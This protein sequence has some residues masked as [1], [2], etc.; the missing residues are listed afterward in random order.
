MLEFKLLCLKATKDLLLDLFNSEGALHQIITRDDKLHAKKAGFL[1]MNK[2]SE[3]LNMYV[4]INQ[5]FKCTKEIYEILFLMIGSQNYSQ[6]NA[7]SDGTI[8][9]LMLD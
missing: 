2:I 3:H 9:S 7:M 1:N 6:L 8:L 5:N 4:D